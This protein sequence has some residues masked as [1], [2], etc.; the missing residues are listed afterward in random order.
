MKPSSAV[1]KTPDRIINSAMVLL[2]HIVV[3]VGGAIF[4]FNKKDVLS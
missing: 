4:I 2:L 1:F 3:F